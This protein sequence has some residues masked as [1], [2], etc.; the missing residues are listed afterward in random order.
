MRNGESR[1][2]RFFLVGNMWYVHNH[3]Y[4]NKHTEKGAHKRICIYIYVY[5]WIR[6]YS[7]FTFNASLRWDDFNL[8]I[9]MALRLNTVTRL[10]S[11]AGYVRFIFS[12]VMRLLFKPKT[13]AFLT[14]SSK[15]LQTI[16]PLNEIDPL[17][18]VYHPDKR[19]QHLF[20]DFPCCFGTYQCSCSTARWLPWP[21]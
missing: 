2:A 11:L 17:A 18:K 9:A 16:V 8:E 3:T 13:I 6:I 21:G 14:F 15:H 4:D 10:E 19:W 7:T 12:E 1:S 5:D 20:G